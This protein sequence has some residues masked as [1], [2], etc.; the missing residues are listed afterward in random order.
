MSQKEY[1]KKVL[2][3]FGMGDYKPRVTPYEVNSNAYETNGDEP[4]DQAMYRQMVGSLIYA[5]VWSC[6]IAR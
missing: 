4:A 2:K 3:K 5:M 1:I 6:K